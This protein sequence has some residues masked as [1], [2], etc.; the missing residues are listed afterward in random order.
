MDLKEERAIGGDPAS[1]WYYI[2]KGRAIRALIGEAHHDGVLDVGAGSGVF[3]RMLTAEGIAERATC[4]DPNYSDAQMKTASTGRVRYVRS[5]TETNASLVLMIDVIEHVDDD[6]AL[7][8][9]YAAIAPAGARF[10]ISVPAFN[11]LWSSHDDFLE[12]RRRYTLETLEQ[13][14]IAAGL[15]PLSTRYF[16]GA[17]FPAVAALRLADRALKGDKQAAASALKAAPEWLNRSLVAIHDVERAA[18]FPF[19]KLAGVTAF[20]LAEKPMLAAESRA[21]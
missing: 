3:S 4:V 1:H 14:V 11:F 9:D 17:L 5:V 12:H 6:V 13:T 18:L 10:I 19:N 7:V 20:C 16:F 8:A 21:A 15:K 2:S